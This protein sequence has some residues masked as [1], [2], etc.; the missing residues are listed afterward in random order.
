MNLPKKVKMVEVG[1]RD[2][3]Q[4]EKREISVAARVGLVDRLSAAGLPVV[5]AG[6]FVSPKWVPQMASSEEVLAKIQRKPGTVYSALTPNMK[7]YQRALEAKA[8]EVAVF[9][10]ASE[11][12]TQRNINCSIEE[13]LER[14]RPLLEQAQKD[15]IRVRGYVSCVLGCPYE[16]EIDPAKVAEVSAALFEMGCYEISLGDTIG[17]GT[18]EKARQMIETVAAKVPQEKLAVHFHDTYG[19]ALANIYAALQ[20]GVAVV[21]SAVAGLGG[22]PYAKG[23]SGNVAS[24]DVLYM[25][26]GLGI[27]TG[28]DLDLLAEAGHFI[29]QKL[30]RDSNSRVARALAD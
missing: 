23:A 18:P 8:D 13:S 16:G 28:V 29:S 9:G 14:F 15:G 17:V 6:S 12:F 21:D 11:S 5:E 24:E 27:E 1:P 19:Q 30:G 7:G 3:L 20:M 26:N 10:A 22:C 4:N 2:G 25:L